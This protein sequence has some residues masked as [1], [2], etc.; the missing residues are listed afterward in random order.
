MNRIG[1]KLKVTAAIAAIVLIAVSLICGCSSGGKEFT[2]IMAKLPG[3][4]VDFGYWAV[5][6]LSA[7]EDLAE[8]YSE[9]RTSSQAQQLMDIGVAL[10]VVEEAARALG[11]DGAVTVIEGDLSRE[12]IERQLKD[13]GYAETRY[14]DTGIWTS[15]EQGELDSLALQRGTMFMGSNDN[16]RSCIDTTTRGQAYSLYDHEYV[17]WLADRL[18]QGL[19]VNVHK[20]GSPSVQEYVDLIA[21]GE[22]YK[23]DREDRLK[24]TA[25]YMFQDSDAAGNARAEI[26][27]RLENNGFTDVKV[28]QDVNYIHVTALISITDFVRNQAF[29]Q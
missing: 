24:V 23:K 21:S 9:F 15:A 22:S 20:A 7:D 26:G 12:D 27:D 2:D 13:N 11:P 3:G 5:G 8:I 16:L 1:M 4:S 25:V 17:R 6:E 14:R 10:F 19:I 18:P 29:W 28:K